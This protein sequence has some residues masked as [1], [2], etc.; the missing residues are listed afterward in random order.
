MGSGP[1]NNLTRQICGTIRLPNS[2]GDAEPTV[3]GDHQEELLRLP[4]Q[5]EFLA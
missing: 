2:D 3:Q 4:R 1:Q 5:A